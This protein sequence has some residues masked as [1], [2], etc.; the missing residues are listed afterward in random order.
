LTGPADW[1]AEVVDRYASRAAR[2]GWP[3]S[4]VEAVASNAEHIRNLAGSA[5]RRRYFAG[6]SEGDQWLFEAVEDLGELVVIRQVL[7]EPN[8][9]THRCSW[10]WI[11]DDEGGLTDEP[12]DPLRGP[13]PTTAA[14]FEEAW[15]GS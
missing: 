7:I 9:A 15:S 11:E 1:S 12:L 6:E 13:S 5:R 2:L 3:P 8:G 10:S 14:C 4:V